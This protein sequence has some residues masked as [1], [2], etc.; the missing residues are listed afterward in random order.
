MYTKHKWESDR[1]YNFN[2]AKYLPKD[3]DESKKYPLVIFLHGAGE[4]GD[5]L[6][7]ACHHGFMKHVRESGT[8]YPFIYCEVCGVNSFDNGYLFQFD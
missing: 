1:Y 5:D 4:R 3:Y 8:E 6:D 2:Y 7:L